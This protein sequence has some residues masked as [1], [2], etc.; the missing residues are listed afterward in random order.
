MKTKFLLGA[1]LISSSII[2]VSAN[3]ADDV[4]SAA[5]KL[6]DESSYSWSTTVIVPADSR[7]KPGPSSG[8]TIKGD[9]T[10]V[11]MSF[12]DNT[13]EIYMKGTNAVLTDPDGGWQTLADAE[14]NDSG[15]AR[16]VGGMVRNF[17]LPAVQAAGLAEDCAEL[18]QT[19]DA[20]AG[21][22]TPDAAKKLLAFRRGNANVSNPSGTATFWVKDG[23]LTKFEVHVKGTV[24]FDD[25]DMDVDRDTTVEI[26]DVGTTTITLPDDVKK[27]MP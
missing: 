12:R 19:N 20:Y 16:F 10:Y 13:T 9:V 18:M 21:A 3:P 2:G 11:K 24:T 6:G 25:N 8:K 1:A 4:S 15:P 5:Q 14:S 17:K 22:L 26:S 7:F 27:L 23:E